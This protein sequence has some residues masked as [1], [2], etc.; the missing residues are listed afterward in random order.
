[1]SRSVSTHSDAVSIVYLNPEQG[2]DDWP[3]F[4][5][6]LKQ[7]LVAR[8]PS[9]SPADR[10]AGNEDHVILDN[11]HAEVSVSEYCGLV[12]V[13]LA[14]RLGRYDYPSVGQ[15]AE[16]WTNQVSAKF[17]E[18]LEKAYASSALKSMGHAS[19]GEQFFTRPGKTLNESC[20][21]SKEGQLW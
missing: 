6:D 11:C 20:I 3:C 18:T 8:F 14:P 1:M 13:C 17:S 5:D 7:I 9:L 19:N 10:W 4:I 15:L 12:A 21:T 16:H 2:E